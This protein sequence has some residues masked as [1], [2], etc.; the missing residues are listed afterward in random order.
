MATIRALWDSNGEL[1]NRDSPYFPLRNAVFDL[2][3][4]KGKWPEIWIAAH[5]PRMLRAVG[6]YADG[7]FPAFPHKPAEY[8][9]RLEAVRT[10][11]SDAGR[12]PMSIVPAM[13]L[14][15]FA[16]RNREEIDESLE[17]AVIKAAALIASDEFFAAHGVDHPLGVGFAGAQDILPQDWDEQTAL[18]HIKGISS[19]LLRQ[20]ALV[21]TPSEVIEQAA[22]WRDCGVRHVVLLHGS[23]LQ[24]SL[25]NGLASMAPFIKI[26]RGLRKL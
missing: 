2:P 7:F 23:V 26:M 19:A 11:A 14:F 8:V 16:G 1:V 6:R 5:G 20:M 21:G 3:P 22:E 24:R 15:V 12:D 18:S 17:S 10:A 25:R 9:R 13:A 4:Y